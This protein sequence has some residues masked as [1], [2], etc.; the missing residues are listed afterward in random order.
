MF[1]LICLIQRTAS[2]VVEKFQLS[3]NIFL[4]V[5][6]VAL[7]FEPWAKRGKCING[8]FFI[9]L[10]YKS[11]LVTAQAMKNRKMLAS[12]QVTFYSTLFTPETFSAHIVNSLEIINFKNISIIVHN[13][14]NNIIQKHQEH[15]LNYP[16]ES[17]ALRC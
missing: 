15:F 4:K 8:N 9:L 12:G 16:F 3:L 14:K 11:K 13:I 5:T 1:G 17:W 10:E 6:N 7:L 2:T